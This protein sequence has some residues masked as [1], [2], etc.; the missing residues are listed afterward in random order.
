MNKVKVLLSSSLSICNIYFRFEEKHLFKEN[1]NHETPFTDRFEKYFDH[2][3]SNLDSTD[4]G[5]SSEKSHGA[6]NGWQHVHKLCCSVLG[7]FVECWGAKIYS[8][9]SELVSPLII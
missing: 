7:D 5:E 1:I 4:N 3:V 2:K 8:Y 9:I 6:S